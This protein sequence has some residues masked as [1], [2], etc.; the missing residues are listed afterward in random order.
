MEVKK[1]ELKDQSIAEI[2]SSRKI[3]FKKLAKG[4][5][6]FTFAPTLVVF[7]MMNLGY[8]NV[9]PAIICISLIFL[10]S[11]MFLQPYIA[12]LE[13]LTNYVKALSEDKTTEK[14]ALSFLNN[15]DELTSAIENLN[16][17]WKKRSDRLEKLADED[18]KKQILL[19][20]FVANAS[21]E[22]KTPL[23][24]I[25]GF[26]ETLLEVENDKDTEKNF[27][28]IIKEQ[29]TRLTKLV[30]DLLILSVAESGVSKK[31]FEILNLREILI[32][33]EISLF[34]QISEKHIDFKTEVSTGLKNIKG[35]YDEVIRVFDN[36]ISNAIK[37]S[38]T[39]S[40]ILVKLYNQD[41][42]VVLEV[43]D[44]G[45]GI[46]EENIPRLTERFFRIDKQR[47]K[48][49]GGSGLGLAIVKHILQNHNAKLEITSKIGQGSC[50]KVSFI[51]LC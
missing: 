17:S 35:N 5:F 51:N 46:S 38:P 19:Q 14:P 8:I 50:F 13:E 43:I 26:V 21:H 32:E 20:D 41:E 16:E 22:M 1:K 23:A 12:D 2:L 36:L 39:N 30:Q 25:S 33:T 28:F 45:E 40:N 37:Y 4:T 18:K 9:L 44:S 29:T 7:A 10:S 6:I 42:K 11:L 3:S 27:L 24:S 15:V 34:K 47:D 31:N 49:I 48:K